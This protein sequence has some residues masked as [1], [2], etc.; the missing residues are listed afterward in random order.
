MQLKLDLVGSRPASS[1]SPGPG[2]KCFF[3]F[4]RILEVK[5]KDQGSVDEEK[6]WLSS[7]AF[8]CQA[9]AGLRGKEP[10]SNPI[11]RYYG[12]RGTPFGPDPENPDRCITILLDNAYY[13]SIESRLQLAYYVTLQSVSCGA[14]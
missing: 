13:A 8:S 4:Q 9:V 1:A 12:V 6:T 10:W 11:L 3:H 2:W 5:R 14:S 7:S